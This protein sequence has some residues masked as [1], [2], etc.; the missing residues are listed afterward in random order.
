VTRCASLALV[1][2]CSIGLVADARAQAKL[3]ARA[4]LPADTFAP[5]PTSGRKL[6][7]LVN[8]RATPF[9]NKQPVQGFS[10]LLDEGDGTFTVLVDNGF[11][12][13]DNSP[14]ARL[15][16]YR[17]RPHFETK[18]GGDGHIEVLSTIVLRDP[19]RKVPFALTEEG[20]PERPLTGADFDPESVQRGRDG[21]LWIGDELGPFLLHV[22]A[23]GRLLEP[24]YAL[25]DGRGGELRAPQNPSYDPARAQAVR[26]GVARCPTSG[27]FEAL[28]IDL[29]QNRLYALLERPLHAEEPARTLRIFEFDIPT[30]RYTGRQL[31]YALD[32]RGT[33]VTDFVLYGDGRG[34][35]IERDE[36]EG[37]LE[38]FK[39]IYD[40][41][42]PAGDGSLEK[43]LLVDLL[44]IQN[45][46]RL[47]G[48][49]SPGDVGLGARFAMPFV[50]IE[51]VAVLSP[52]HLA[53]VNDNNYPKSIGR[54][55]GTRQPDDS[56]LVIVRLAEPLRRVRVRT[57]A[58]GAWTYY[59]L[60]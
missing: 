57:T 13:V 56:E 17:V 22:A 24:P 11:G 23:D 40:V 60:R 34:L 54:H 16:L 26:E 8:G 59:P 20:T 12:S 53:I 19:D 55:V 29:V 35:V 9:V 46:A 28:A 14:D 38:G 18:A 44:A 31:R 15:R 21:T 51:S 32:P 5:G 37:S 3:V 2:A 41:R 36:S 49:G 45:D 4:V 30:R 52:S 6:P 48:D 27:G 10:G 42:L 43:R 50:T 58:H 1:L 7:P 25:P 47:G 39:A 33:S